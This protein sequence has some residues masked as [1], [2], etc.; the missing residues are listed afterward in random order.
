MLWGIN[1]KYITWIRETNQKN[2]PAFYQKLYD[3]VDLSI[4]CGMMFRPEELDKFISDAGI[5]TITGVKKPETTTALEERIKELEEEN[6][7]LSKE[8]EEL[9][10]I[11]MIK[12]TPLDGIEADSKV[13]LTEVLKLMENDGANFEKSKNKTIGAKALKMMTGRSASACKQIFSNPLSPTYPQHK[14]KIAE[15]NGYL[16]T[17]GMK[18]LL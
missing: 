7:R 9:K 14:K 10:G 15:L 13:G 16:K 17:L 6:E 18:T 1:N 4:K 12:D 2:A 5:N 11:K 8:Y 3:L